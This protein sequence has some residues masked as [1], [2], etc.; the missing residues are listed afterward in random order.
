MTHHARPVPSTAEVLER[1]PDLTNVTVST[2]RRSFDITTHT[3]SN[4][5]R[6]ARREAA[7]RFAMSHPERPT[8]HLESARI[9]ALREEYGFSAWEARYFIR[10]ESGGESIST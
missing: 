9:R 7:R 8:V 3:A 1:F 2:L 10:L 4:V 6:L 5:L